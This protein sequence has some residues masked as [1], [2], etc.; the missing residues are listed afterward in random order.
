MRKLLFYIILAGVVYGFFFCN[1]Q[2]HVDKAETSEKTETATPVDQKPTKKAKPKKV[3]KKEKPTP[4]DDYDITSLKAVKSYKISCNGNV[5][6]LNVPVK[7][8]AEELDAQQISYDPANLADC[9]G[10]FH[11][12]LSAF[13]AE[14]PGHDLPTPQKNRDSRA[15]AKW[16]HEQGLLT[17]IDDEATQQELIK[18][19]AVLFYGYQGKKYENF[20]A[21][22]LFVRGTGIDHV[23]VVV[24][25]K[26]DAKGNIIN[27]HLFHGRNPKHPAG[28]TTYHYFKP[29]RDS[30]PP[31]GNGS[32]QWVAFAL[33][34]EDILE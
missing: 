24:E 32:Q 12:F 5:N 10:I 8:I 33:L 4:S 1:R 6:T 26:R 29:S 30:Y 27:Y 3:A 2:S 22:E 16:Y 13:K 9:S 34:V 18:P 31:L 21:K 20:K 14:C 25:V 11:R 17:L 28:I 23:G 19:G 15:L 7:S